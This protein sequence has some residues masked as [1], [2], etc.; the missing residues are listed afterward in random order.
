MDSIR[1]DDNGDD[2]PSPFPT[3]IIWVAVVGGQKR[4]TCHRF[5]GVVDS[6][7]VWV[8]VMGIC[9]LPVD[10][11]VDDARTTG[12]KLKGKHGLAKS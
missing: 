12:L 11:N 1:D 8:M 4:Q 10:V 9:N 5:H 2:W 3:T 7:M 6:D